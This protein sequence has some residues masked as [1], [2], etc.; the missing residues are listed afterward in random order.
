MIC[1]NCEQK[2]EGNYC[3]NCGQE[4]N[5]GNISLK[6]TFNSILNGLFQLDRG[7]FF[8]IKELFLKPGGSIRHY[9]EGKRK[10]YYNPFSLI[11]LS[12]LL[13]LLVNYL[14]KYKL[15][16]IE[17]SNAFINGIAGADGP[18]NTTILMGRIIEWFSIH[19]AYM[20]LMLLPI[21]SLSSFFAFK[22]YGYSYLEHLVLNAY[23]KGVEIIFLVAVSVSN[24][25]VKNEDILYY[26]QIII[27]FIYTFW[28]YFQFFNSKNWRLRIIHTI[29]TYFYYVLF[30]VFMVLI[31]LVVLILTLDS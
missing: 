19:Y 16:I 21:I 10:K 30:I 3:N 9:I 17:F 8:T 31:L 18:K 6:Q 11:I 25:F 24:I 2:F 28:V 29:L 23:I 4:S 12:S 7:F 22:K 15:G 14:T 26:C 27:V 1:K 20:I 13:L 5:V